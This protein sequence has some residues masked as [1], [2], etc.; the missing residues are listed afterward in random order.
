MMMRCADWMAQRV[1]RAFC[2]VSMVMQELHNTF[3]L[4]L[5]SLKRQSILLVSINA[6]II[7]QHDLCANAAMAQLATIFGLNYPFVIQ[8]DAPSCYR[9][10]SLQ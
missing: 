1:Q 6:Y 4:S 10:Q 2:S 7:Y 9:R 5:L 8:P 3:I